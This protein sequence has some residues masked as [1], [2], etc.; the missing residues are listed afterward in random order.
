MVSP[1]TLALRHRMAAL[2]PRE[3]PVYTPRQPQPDR[4]AVPIEMRRIAQARHL[5]T[6]RRVT[7]SNASGRDGQPRTIP[8]GGPGRRRA[9]A[10]R[11]RAA[12]EAIEAPRFSTGGWVTGPTE[13]V[14]TPACTYVLPPGEAARLIGDY[15]R[16]DN[17]ATA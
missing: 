11:N 13:P 4:I 7:A 15:W 1:N 10:I 8:I 3:I 12:G 9:K 16:D 5:R 2:Q 14:A 17:E 6:R